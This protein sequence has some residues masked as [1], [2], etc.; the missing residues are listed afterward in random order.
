MTNIFMGEQKVFLLKGL[1][2]EY[3]KMV[4]KKGIIG[5]NVPISNIHPLFVPP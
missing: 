3:S 4:K 5:K 2:G 1:F